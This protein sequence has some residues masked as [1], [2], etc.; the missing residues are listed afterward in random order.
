MDTPT[1]QAYAY[2]VFDLETTNGSEDQVHFW[3]RLLLKVNE[4]HKLDTAIRKAVEALDRRKE[5]AA[6]LPSSPIICVSLKSESEA[7]VLH[8]MYVHQP[9]M[10][11]EALIEGFDNERDMLRT[12]RNLMDARVDPNTRLVAHNGRRFD[13]PKLRGGFARHGIRLPECF[14]GG[15]QQL[16]D[17]MDVYC[18]YFSTER[19]I[20]ISLSEVCEDLHIGNPKDNI[21]GSQVPELHA[22]G[23]FDRLIAYALADVLA[24]EAVYLRLTGQAGDLE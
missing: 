15:D 14:I 24:E 1:S 11:G 20:M 6:L 19:D 5:L 2:L 3:W 12:L 16:V 8:Q 9:R 23:E 18:R 13:A 10:Q 21:D 22:A 17:L 4:R 7:R